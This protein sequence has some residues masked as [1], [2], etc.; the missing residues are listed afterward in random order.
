MGSQIQYRLA[1]MLAGI[2]TCSI[3]L[4]AQSSGV[5]GGYTLGFVFD[6]RISALKPLVGIPG[7]AVLGS[8]LDAG[9]PLAQAF[10]SPRQNFAMAL[11]DAGVLV[12]GLGSAADR[13]GVTP[14]GLDS[15]AASLVAI[16]P[17]GSAAALYSAADGV[18]R[19][20]TG[21]PSAPVVASSIP[22]AAV[23]SGMRLLALSDD[24][25]VL[26]A[27][28]DT[29][30]GGALV[31]LDSAGN[32]R[33]VL[34]SSHISALRFIG[35]TRDLLV[36]DDVDDTVS[37]VAAAGDAATPQLLAAAADGVAGPAAV[38]VTSD[39]RLVVVANG[40]AGN[41]FVFDPKGSQR[42]TYAC[43][44]APSGLQ[45]L[46]GNSVFLLNDVSGDNPLWLFDGDSATPRVVFIP[47]GQSAPGGGQ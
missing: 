45:R 23:G 30:G 21:L 22:A 29:A 31:I 24:G 2:V 25:S 41:V 27:A 14:L 35:D 1:C 19:V 40:R 4:G 42:A 46:N 10:V 11:A 13:P 33:T 39:R 38:D 43:P 17:D 3:P 47:A 12:V 8:P 6:G 26:A 44:C 37:L 20:I 18:I 16:S 15:S 34:N 28:V 7:A 9:A 5:I 36:A 32:A